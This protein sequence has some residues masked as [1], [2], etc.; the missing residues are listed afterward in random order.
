MSVDTATKP[1]LTLK[2]HLKA[3]PAKVFAAWVDPEK[4]KRWLTPHDMQEAHAETDLRVGG[5]YRWVMRNP[6]TNEENDVRGVY[7]EIVANQKLVFS[8]AWKSTPERESLVTVLLQPD[9]DGTLL[10][11]I[12][13]NFFDADAR[14]RHQH[15]WNAILDKL[16]T[17]VAQAT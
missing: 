2:R 11:L 15:G 5:R 3:S 16:T 9:G 4:I 17:F 1:S 10:T 13:E 8:W 6:K 7:R 12:H 14:D